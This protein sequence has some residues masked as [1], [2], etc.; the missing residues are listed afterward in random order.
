MRNRKGRIFIDREQVTNAF[1]VFCEVVIGLRS[2][3]NPQVS[4]IIGVFD[5]ENSWGSILNRDSRIDVAFNT[6]HAW[7]HSGPQM[8]KQLLERIW[9]DITHQQLSG[10]VRDGC[11]GH[12]SSI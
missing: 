9:L 2:H 12:I 6:F 7:C 10:G 3:R 11:H 4:T 5:V 1:K 8:V